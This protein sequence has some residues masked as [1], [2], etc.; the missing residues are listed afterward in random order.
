MIE[1]T[2]TYLW[3]FL[4]Q[5]LNEGFIFDSS[6]LSNI[7]LNLTSFTRC[8]RIRRIFSILTKIILI[9]LYFNQI[10]IYR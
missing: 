10:Y 2:Y 4:V 5:I 6:C 8:Q 1:I 3:I 7:F 9:F